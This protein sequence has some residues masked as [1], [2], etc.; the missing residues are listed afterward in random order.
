MSGG[1]PE[2]KEAQ[3]S[4]KAKPSPG[5]KKLLTKMMHR[6]SG[7][8]GFKTLAPKADSGVSGADTPPRKIMKKMMHRQSGKDGFKSLAPKKADASVLGANGSAGRPD[9][10]PAPQQQEQQP[11]SDPVVFVEKK[12]D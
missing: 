9:P 11:A 12:K 5:G 4:A 2:A 8:D 3:S 10:P 1:A 6:Q 7:K